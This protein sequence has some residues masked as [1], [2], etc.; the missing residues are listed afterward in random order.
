[1]DTTTQYKATD[2]FLPPDYTEADLRR[3][4][5][6]RLHVAPAD[7]TGV[8]LARLGL[9]A[10]RRKVHYTASAL[11]TVRPE[12]AEAAHLEAWEPRSYTFPYANLN[13]E[14]RP[15]VVGSGPA[16]IFCALE[17]ARA[18]LRPIVLEQGQAVEQRVAD[19][20]AFTSGGPLRPGSNI[21]FGEGGAG[22]FSDD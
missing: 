21:Q 2:L 9:D 15:V 4:A 18:G 22:T 20:E 5:A 19:V 16:G 11:C 17:L 13:S 8:E 1:M 10:R 14:F 6:R 7:I 12:A 3:A